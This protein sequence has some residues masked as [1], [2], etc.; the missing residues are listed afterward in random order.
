MN[1]NFYSGNI[2]IRAF[3]LVATVFF[4]CNCTAQDSNQQPSSYRAF[5]ADTSLFKKDNFINRFGAIDPIYN[6]IKNDIKRGKFSVLEHGYD[7]IA[8]RLWYI[9]AD[10]TTQVVELRKDDSGWTAEF[11]TIKREQENNGKDTIVTVVRK[12]VVQNPVSGWESFTKKIFALNITNLPNADDIPS[13][14]MPMGGHYVSIEVSTKTYYRLRWYPAPKANI[15]IKEAR[16]LE[17]I[18]KLIEVEFGEKRIR[19][20]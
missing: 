17:D 6:F 7:S 5:D 14:D 18:M 13:Y 15:N 19:V 10:P 12:V 20:I 4:F 11:F 2:L 3:S 9:Y 16:A 1:L 8:I